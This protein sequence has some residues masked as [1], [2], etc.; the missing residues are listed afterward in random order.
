M[1]CRRDALDPFLADR[2]GRAYAMGIP[3]VCLSVGD[4]GGSR[5]NGWLDR[6]AVWRRDLWGPKTHCIRWGPDPPREG[7]GC[8]AHRKQCANYWYRS[9]GHPRVT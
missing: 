3:S 1:V 7:L 6:D 9:G 8:L 4:V 5:S 2:L